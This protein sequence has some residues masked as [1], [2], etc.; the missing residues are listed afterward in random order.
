[1]V[2]EREKSRIPNTFNIFEEVTGRVVKFR[3]DGQSRSGSYNLGAV[4]D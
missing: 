4:V 2:V 1:M 3:N